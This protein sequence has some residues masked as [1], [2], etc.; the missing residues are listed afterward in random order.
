MWYQCVHG[1]AI[2]ALVLSA[3]L[4]QLPL[5]QE[6]GEIYG[7]EPMVNVVKQIKQ[8]CYLCVHRGIAANVISFWH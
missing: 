5:L 1:Q 3:C 7:D 6:Y 2:A 4:C 8:D